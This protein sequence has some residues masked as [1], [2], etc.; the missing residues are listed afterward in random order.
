MPSWPIVLAAELEKGVIRTDLGHLKRLLRGRSDSE[1]EIVIQP[2]REKRSAAANAYYWSVVLNAIS[3]YSGYDPNETHEAMKALFLPKE[4]AF[5]DGN[6]VV[7]GEI[8]I[9]GSTR[10]MTVSEFYD[11]V[12]RV[13]RFAAEKL[14]LNIPDPDPNWRDH[15]SETVEAQS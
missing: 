13:R 2:K 11:Y 5:C 9:G 4:L 15:E 7:Q 14:L 12:E 10:K 3:E 8:V 6:G 1:L